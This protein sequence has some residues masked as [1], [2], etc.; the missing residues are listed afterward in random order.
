MCI[1]LNVIKSLVDEK[2]LMWIVNVREKDVFNFLDNFYD[3]G[4]IKKKN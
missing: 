1:N 4:G 2:R 3:L